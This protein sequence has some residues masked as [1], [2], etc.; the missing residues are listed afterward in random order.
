VTTAF[1]GINSFI[2]TNMAAGFFALCICL[3]VHS[4]SHDCRA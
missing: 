3:I 1:A 4:P 2:K